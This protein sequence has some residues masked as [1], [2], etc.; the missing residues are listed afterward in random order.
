MIQATFVADWYWATREPPRLLRWEPRPAE[1][2]DLVVLPLAT[3]PVDDR[4]A[5]TMFVL[6][7]IHMA[8]RRLWIASPY[9]VPD[10]AILYG[11]ELA[12]VRGVDV[13]ILIPAQPDHLMVYLAAFSY[14]EEMGAAGV[15]VYRFKDGFLHQ[16][17]L[18]VDDDIVSVGTANLD[19]RS[20]RLNFEISVLVVDRVFAGKVADMLENDFA[21]SALE[22][23]DA[24]RKRDPL[25]RF[26]VRLC[27]L[28]APIL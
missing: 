5:C 12:A 27:R 18:L 16:K 22:S 25:F 15:Q 7:A 17:V 24:F 26:G 2:D 20:L 9:F 1:N 14:L 19:N 6:N 13:R 8:K 28:F 3:G 23:V 4:E 11:L 21:H 10:E